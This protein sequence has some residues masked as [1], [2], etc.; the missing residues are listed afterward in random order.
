MR[1]TRLAL[2]AWLVLLLVSLLLYGVFIRYDRN[3]YLPIARDIVE[4]QFIDTHLRYHKENKQWFANELPA[5]NARVEAFVHTLHAPCR[6]QYARTDL[7]APEP[8][9]PVSM[10]IND[11]TF[12]IGAH[13]NLSATHYFY[14]DSQ[15]YLCHESIKI[16]AQ[17]PVHTWLEES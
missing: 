7:Q 9:S 6:A 16:I 1:L 12:V 13:Q 2:S 14:H 3:I 4:L 15:V 5:D 17:Q 8:H 10:R 11:Q